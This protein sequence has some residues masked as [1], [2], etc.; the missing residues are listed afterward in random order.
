MEARRTEIDMVQT[1]K[2]V[3]NMDTDNSDPWFERATSRR[4]TRNSAVRHNLA[5]KRGQHEFR[6]NFF[7]SRV[8]VTWNSQPEA[9]RDAPTVSRFKRYTGATWCAR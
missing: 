6:R 5:P 9:V 1:Y 3:K 8:I 4:V 2:M 7:S